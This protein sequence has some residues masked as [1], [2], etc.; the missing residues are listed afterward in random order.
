MEIRRDKTDRVSPESVSPSVKTRTTR[1]MQ[2]TV[3]RSFTCLRSSVPFR[4]LHGRREN[5]VTDIVNVGGAKI[6]DGYAIKE[7][8]LHN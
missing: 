4:T 6:M 5:T 1:T 8:L 7:G 2:S 3:G